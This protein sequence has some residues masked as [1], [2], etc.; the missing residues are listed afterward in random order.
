MKEITDNCPIPGW[1]RMI[2]Q[3]KAG[4]TS[5]KFDVYFVEPDGKRL[6]SRKEISNYLEENGLDISLDLFCFR[7]SKKLSERTLTNV[8]DRKESRARPSLTESCYFSKEKLASEDG[9]VLM[10][11][12]KNLSAKE[13]VNIDLQVI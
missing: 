3:R 7:T 11:A 10:G 13:K 1:K 2:C 12:R 4:K 8:K 9:D 5:G 6:R